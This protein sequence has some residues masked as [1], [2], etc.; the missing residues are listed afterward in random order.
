LGTFAIVNNGRNNIRENEMIKLITRTMVLGLILGSMCIIGVAKENKKHV[1]F[2]E[3]VT[4]NGTLVKPGTYAVVF[5]DVTGQ[6]T[7]F[8]GK[9]EIAKAS[10][11]LEKL[12]RDTGQVYSSWSNASKSEEPGVLTSVTMKDGYQAKL[13][14]A[15][16]MRTEGSQ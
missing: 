2:D 11:R 16:E 10:A 4:V 13:V 7:I 8:K 12:E 1:T 14:N 9:K 15:G 5:D 6:L 3:P